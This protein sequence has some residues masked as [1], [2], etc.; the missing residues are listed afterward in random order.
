[1]SVISA[2]P[3]PEG[4]PEQS[5]APIAAPEFAAHEMRGQSIEHL[6]LLWN[7]RRFLSRVASLGF[8][9]GLL[10][11]FVLP[12]EYQST[13][14]LMPD[15]SSSTGVLMAAL[16]GA[17]NG[18][19]AIAGNLLG[20]RS[21]GE[22]FIGILHSRTVQDRLVQRFNL[23]KLYDDK[24]DEDAR[25]DL[26]ANTGIS[27]DRKSGIISI[28]V[29][30]HDPQRAK[31]V[32]QG[33]IDELD[34]LAA[35]LSTSAAHRERVFLE[36]RLKAV[37]QDLDQAARDFSEFASKN[38]AIDITAQGKAM[39]ESA[40]VLQGQ[41]IAAQA[42]L[43]GLEQIYQPNNVRVRSVHARVAELQRQLEKLGGETPG[44]ADA[45]AGDEKSLYPSI[46]ELPILGVTYFDLYRRTKIQEAVYEALTKEY[47]MAKVQEAKETPSVKVLDSA[48]VPEKISF[49]PRILTMMLCTFFAFIGGMV[50]VS[51][52]ARW[53]R[54]DADDPAKL[55][56]QEVF[57]VMNSRMPWATPNG[58][59]VQ[60]MTHQA[61][62]RLV[63]RNGS[64]RPP[65]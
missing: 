6:R 26:A 16:S 24:L 52:R 62:L 23:K 53:N 11:A 13:V 5:L 35:E 39:L 19:A 3:Q 45:P 58:S 64:A 41:M 55:L 15:G 9:A 60:A 48:N 38:T 65:E 17:S 18:L 34:R 20:A 42:E 37:K 54:V 10:L 8:V 29:T 43:K 32:A 1:M 56:A 25:K 27:S 47:E 30:D 57:Q 36:G 22:Q 31:A 51:G 21:T 33:Y 49:P 61:W 40:A 7:E 14:Q 12:K 44:S 4:S 2:R 59:R 50:W 46:R 28:V 63:R